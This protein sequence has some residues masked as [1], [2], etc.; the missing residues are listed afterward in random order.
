MSVTISCKCKS[1]D[2]VKFL[3]YMTNVVKG[4]TYVAHTNRHFYRYTANNY[5]KNPSPLWTRSSVQ[6]RESACVCQWHSQDTEAARA[7][8]LYAA[9]DSA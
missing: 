9:E 7:Q 6:S 8:G 3:I 4:T 1:A 2:F 5:W